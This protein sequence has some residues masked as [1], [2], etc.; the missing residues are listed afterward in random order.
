MASRLFASA[1]LV[2]PSHAPLPTHRMEVKKTHDKLLLN[3]LSATN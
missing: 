3:G 2:L 1:V